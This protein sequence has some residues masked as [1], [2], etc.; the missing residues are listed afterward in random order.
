[1]KIFGREPAL[2]VAGIAAIL[3]LIATFG[4]PFLTDT[5]ATVIVAV[6][7]AGA[8]VVI[9]IRTRPIAPGAFLTFVSAV[10]AVL[11]AYGVAVPQRTVGAV[12]LVVLAVLALITR[13]QVSPVPPAAAKARVHAADTRK[14]TER[15]ADDQAAAARWEG[16][17]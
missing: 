3:G 13:G 11:T 9:A 16:G 15:E 7:D 14:T 10:V 12:D 4:L 1:M 5:E 17:R 2:W 6:V 8:G